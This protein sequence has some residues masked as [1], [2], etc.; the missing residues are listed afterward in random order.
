[1]VFDRPRIKEAA[2]SIVHEA[3]PRPWK[4]FL[5]YYLIMVAIS[6]IAALVITLPLLLP[7]AS[8]A[9]ASFPWAPFLLQLLLSLFNALMQIGS[10]AYCLKLW[11]KEPGGFRDL[12]QGFRIPGKALALLGLEVLFT[13]LWTLLGLAV[14]VLLFGLVSILPYDPVIATVFGLT[15]YIGF[16]IY[17][18]NR[19]F[20]YSMVFYLLLDHPYWTARQALR[21]SKILMADRKWDYFVL[22]LSFLG[23]GALVFVIFYAVMAIPMILGGS[24]LLLF[25][26]PAAYMYPNLLSF[27]LAFLVSAPLSLWLQA[28][29]GSSIAGFYDWAA[30]QSQPPASDARPSPTSSWNDPRSTEPWDSSQDPSGEGK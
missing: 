7:S 25:R 17:L 9:P 24:S 23:W 30:Y 10:K 11:R 4:V 6:V 18:L 26:N 27:F 12:F 2:R 13:F 5:I 8:T 15:C 16:M 29:W 1:M 28:Y 20:R 3:Q 22:Q 19:I 21:A 14:Y